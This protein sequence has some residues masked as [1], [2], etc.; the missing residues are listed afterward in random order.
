MGFNCIKKNTS[1]A[2]LIFLSR[3][4]SLSRSF[5]LS[6]FLYLSLCPL[7]LSCGLADFDLD[8]RGRESKHWIGYTNNEE[9]NVFCWE[10]SH[11]KSTLRVFSLRSGGL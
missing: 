8:F 2:I 7:L 6:L 11:S 3:P 5:L 1:Q 4:L 9:I 10:S